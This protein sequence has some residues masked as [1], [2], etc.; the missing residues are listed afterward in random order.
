MSSG[1]GEFF[2]PAKSVYNVVYHSI[3]RNFMSNVIVVCTNNLVPAILF[4]RVLSN[5]FVQAD[6]LKDTSVVVVSH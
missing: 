1:Q 5:V 6:I 2:S 3:E 4:R